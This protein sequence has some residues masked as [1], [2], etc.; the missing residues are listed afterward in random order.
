MAFN[1]RQGLVVHTMP[2]FFCFND[3]YRLRRMIA[4]KILPERMPMRRAEK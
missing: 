4:V 1:L 3:C 2:C